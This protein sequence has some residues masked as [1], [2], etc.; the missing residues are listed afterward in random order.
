M[1][2]EKVRVLLSGNEAVAHGAREAGVQLAT[3]YP[4]TP[5]TEIL[6][7]LAKFPGVYAQWSPNEKVA[8]EV[9]MGGSMAGARTLVAMKHVGVNV[10]ADPLMT[11]SYTGIKGGFVLVS[12]DD[13]GMHSSQNEQDNRFYAKFAKIP[14]LEPS[15]SQEA[16]DFVG[17]ALDISERFDTPVLLR[18]TTRISHSKGIVELGSRKEYPVSGFDR[19]VT[20][21]VMMPIYARK[22]HEVVEERMEKLRKFTEETPLN[23]VEEGD[24]SLG[25]VA[26]GISYNYAKEVLPDASYLKVGFSNPLPIQR[27]EKFARSVD[28]LLVIEELEPFM[29]E[30]IRGAGIHCRGKEFVPNQGELTPE[31]LKE[32]LVRASILSGLTKEDLTVQKAGG[33]FP[34][35]PVLCP[36][37]AH[38]GL[39]CALNKLKADVLGDIG[40][41][42]LAALPPLEALHSCICMGASIGN[43]I[44]V[45]RV[46]NPKA[47]VV[48][49]IGDSTFLHSGMTPLLDAVY[50]KSNIT[51]IIMDNRIT[52]MTGGQH[53]PATGNTLMGEKTKAVDFW[54][55]SKALGVDQVFTVDPYDYNATLETLKRAVILPGLKVVISRGPCVIFPKK[56]RGKPYRINLEECNG[57]G[58][59]LRLG[60]PAISAS[61]ERTDKGLAKAIID[62]SLCTG[63][64]LCAQICPIDV[65]EAVG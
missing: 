16:K 23:R 35:P 54:A 30:Q 65:I 51:V 19:N 5:S 13:P 25:V 21:Y 33:G 40:C 57:C 41:Y 27:I 12:A 28:Q 6:E 37:C 15:D 46:V 56:V 26:G 8:F 34:R 64:D 59:C 50:N 63:C 48:A 3:A 49:V 53:H 32:G 4:G 36:G 18:L 61:E 60:C 20:K 31:K 9:G 14:M 22:R 39:Y 62:E 2:R 52:A 29:E 17:I 43:A 38:R 1:D 42:T 45:E 44:G 24:R 55:L 7:N 47:P 11:F 10:A 58:A